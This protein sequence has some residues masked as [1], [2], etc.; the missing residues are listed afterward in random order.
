[1]NDVILLSNIFLERGIK[2]ILYN[3]ITKMMSCF[4][5]WNACT[6]EVK[7][8][9]FKNNTAM[10]LTTFTCGKSSFITNILQVKIDPDIFNVVVNSEFSF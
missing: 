10:N 5:L 1:M 6:S 3:S 7:G 4:L 9:G 8:N 2:I